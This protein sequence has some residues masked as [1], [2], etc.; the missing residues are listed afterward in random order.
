MAKIWPVYDGNE[1]TV[2][3]PWAKVPMSDV[4]WLFDLK[5][6]DFLGGLNETPRPRFG[7]QNEAL[8]HRGYKHVVVEIEQGEARK[9][10]WKPGFYKA[11]TTPSE[12]FNLLI[13]DALVHTFG[14]DSVLRIL[15]EPAADSRG[16]DAVKLTVVIAPDAVPKL[17]EK[18]LD[19]LVSVQN[20]L[21]EMREDRTPIIEFATEEEL[22][23]NADP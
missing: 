11:R 3:G 6:E 17:T 15:R 8:S 16:H 2:G 20:R 23:Q 12:A 14:R 5:Q 1:P 22:D 7:N 13:K 9:A 4:I 10:K 19:A 18:S 21:S